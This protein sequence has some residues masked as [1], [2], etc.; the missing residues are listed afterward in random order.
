MEKAWKDYVRVGLRDQ[1]ILDLYDNYDFHR[2]RKDRFDRLSS[3]I[4][5]GNYEPKPAFIARLEKKLGLCR[6]IVLPSPEDAVILQCITESLLKPAL[7]SQP[8]KN[9]FFSRS[10]STPDSSF[11]FGKDYIWFKRYRAFAKRRIE[12]STAHDW[13]VV[14]DIANCFDSV[15]HVHLRN[16]LANL[17]GVKEVTLDIL[18]R[19]IPA[20]SWRPDYL[21]LPPQGLPQVQFDAP[22]LLSHVYLYETD[23]FLESRTDGFVRWVDDITAAVSSRERGY[24]LLRDVDALL[25]L[26]G[27]R[28][29]AG[30]TYVL[31]KA[32]AYRHFA[33]EENKKLASYSTELDKRLK[34]GWKT[35]GLRKRLLSSFN[36]VISKCQSPNLDKVVKQY[37]RIFIKLRSDDILDFCCR[38][39]I[40][41]PSLREMILDYFLEIGPRV[42]TFNAVSSFLI[43]ERCL[44][45]VSIAQIAKLF[46]DWRIEKN[47][48][49]VRRM[50]RLAN[51][52][53]DERYLR[54][55]S[56]YLVASVWIL[57]KYGTPAVLSRAI[58][59]TRPL[60]ENSDFLA[61]QVAAAIGRFKSESV[62]EDFYRKLRGRGLTAT[63]S[64]L[65]DQ[66][67][68]RNLKSVVPF[69]IRGY[70]LNGGNKTTY[71]LSRFLIAKNVLAN[72][73]LDKVHRAKLQADI[74][75]YVNDPI[76]E[77][78]IRA[79][80]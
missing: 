9:V 54:R 36:K 37:I 2:T 23:S 11:T 60:W 24:R 33:I 62:R 67:L 8:S 70:L 71:T 46:T 6:P 78:E 35:D 14:T 53:S 73:D 1:P 4:L 77:A 5:A 27:Q 3:Q 63:E 72:L 30:K 66:E 41:S 22:R 74:I 76:F 51:E 49:L 75:K 68:L 64:V 40:T 15:V 44:D 65:A 43:S 80:V 48:S 38:E 28:L 55:S 32:E 42:K 58:R 79:A 18:F 59:T 7:A 31:S 39:L 56:V 61:R 45:D 16:Q 21:P 20:V 50:V 57:A 34:K 47:S 13:V 26:R 17:D 29:N 52:I 19:M 25:H 10:H 69:E 12:L